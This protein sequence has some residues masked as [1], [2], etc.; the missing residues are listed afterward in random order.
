MTRM[1]M[2]VGAEEDQRTS[3]FCGVV[4]KVCP[5]LCA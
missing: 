2:D 1:M 5:Y 3:L 4:Q